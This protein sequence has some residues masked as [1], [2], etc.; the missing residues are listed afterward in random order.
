MVIDL[1]YGNTALRNNL[2][3][4]SVVSFS[5]IFEDECTSSLL[6]I[7]LLIYCPQC[8]TFFKKR[9]CVTFLCVQEL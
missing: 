9:I 6:F 8:S 2:K 1:G 7:I 3:S 4:H 5:F